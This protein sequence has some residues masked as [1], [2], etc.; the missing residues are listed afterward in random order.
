MILP[1]KSLYRPD[2]VARH[3]SVHINTILRW[4]AEEKLFAIR[5]NRLL[6]IPRE[7]LKEFEQPTIKK[8]S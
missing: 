6:R 4:I 5:I 8:H 1:E 7:A 3:Y 2:E